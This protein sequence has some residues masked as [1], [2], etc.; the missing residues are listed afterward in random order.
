M[1]GRYIILS[2]FAVLLYFQINGANAWVS[3]VPVIFMGNIS[4]IYSK[5]PIFHGYTDDFLNNPQVKQVC[6]GASN[7]GVT[8]D[9]CSLI[10]V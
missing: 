6:Q 4:D 8:L 5:M 1:F 9:Y 10:K 2:V 3:Y 7:D